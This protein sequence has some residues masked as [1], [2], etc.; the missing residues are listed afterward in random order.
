MQIHQDLPELWRFEVQRAYYMQWW[1][2]IQVISFYG[3]HNFY[4]PQNQCHSGLVVRAIVHCSCVH[5]LK[6]PVGVNLLEVRR[7]IFSNSQ[8]P[9]SYMF[10]LNE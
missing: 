3:I 9:R 8:R 1:S 7:R 10:F 5:E 6:S 2:A 4:Q